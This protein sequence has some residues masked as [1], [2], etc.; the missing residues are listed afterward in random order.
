AAQV[1]SRSGFGKPQKT[2]TDKRP[3]G[4]SA[5]GFVVFAEDQADV[6]TELELERLGQSLEGW[7]PQEV[8]SWA[9]DRYPRLTFATGFDVEGCCIID[10]IAR[11]KL[12][13]DLFSLDTGLLFPETYDLWKK[14]EAKYGITIRAVKPELDVE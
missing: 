4:G 9:S 8:L 13:I 7:P 3:G 1:P 14:L 2:P 5:P 6:S 10:M 11:Q 12:P